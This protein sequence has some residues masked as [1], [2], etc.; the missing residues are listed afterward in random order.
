MRGLKFIIGTVAGLLLATTAVRADDIVDKEWSDLELKRAQMLEKGSLEAALKIYDMMAEHAEKQG[1]IDKAA[2][3]RRDKVGLLHNMQQDSLLIEEATRQMAWMEQ[4]GQKDYFYR[5]W[6]L[7]AESYYFSH[8]PQTALRQAKLMLEYAQEHGDDQGRANAYQQMGFNYLEVDNDEAIKTYQHSI[9]LFR[10]M[11]GDHYGDLNR[12]YGYL[13]EALENKKDYAAELRYCEEWR[14]LLDEWGQKAKGKQMIRVNIEHHLQT[15]SA[16]IGLSRIDEAEQQLAEAERLNGIEKDDY[17]DYIIL[18]RKTQAAYDAGHYNQA[19]AYSDRFA[20]MMESDDWV[21][22]RL[23][24]AEALIKG[25]R[26]AEAAQIYRRLYETKDST[27]SKDMRMQ[28]DELNTLFQVDELK[29]QNQL[30]RSRLFSAFFGCALLG[31]LL[32][33]YFRH[34]SAKR[35]AEMKSAQERIENELSIARDIQMSMV[36]HQFPERPGL[37]LYAWMMP[38][39]EVGGDFYGYR[40]YGD[41]LYF[42]IGDVSGKGVPASL[43]MAQATRLFSTFAEQGMMPAEI[44]THM[45]NALSGEDNEQGM[46]VTMFLGLVDLK[47]GHLDFCNAGHNPPVLGGDEHQGSFLEM[48]PN[49]PI[50]LWPGLEFVGEAIES[51]KGRPLFI[52]TDG[53]NEA[54]NTRHEQFGDDRLLSSLRDTSYESSRQV[55]ET[56]AALVEAHRQGADPNDDLTMMCLRL[57]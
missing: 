22:P 26:P 57:S 5:I 2:S 40:L 53:L 45:N 43:F 8:K 33:L 51:I 13:C 38:A 16:L 44:C 9:R 19:V 17:Y 47:T 11:S 14:Q 6:R 3:V 56:L 50:G 55:I 36:P 29:I 35:L 24:R 49:A 1:R 15:A 52:Y 7:M 48:E 25:N 4:H 54:E 21:L 32:F 41:R 31:L 23:V 20:P 34:R 39:R 10:Q 18:V 27:F 46:F 12:S 42:C 37:D 30:V 28:L